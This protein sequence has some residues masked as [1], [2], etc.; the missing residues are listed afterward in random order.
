MIFDY[1]LTVRT[2]SLDFISPTPKIDKTMVWIRFPGLNLIYYEE[3]S[4]VLALAS[5]VGR[6]IKVD[7]NTIRT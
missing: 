4:I 2:W 7:N 1:Y 6:P 5:A 3:K